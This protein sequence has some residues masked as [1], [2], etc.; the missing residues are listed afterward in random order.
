MKYKIISAVG[1]IL[2][3]LINISSCKKYL[4]IKPDKS[5]VV[6]SSLNDLQ[7]MLDDAMTMN[8]LWP[9]G[10]EVYSDSYYVTDDDWKSLPQIDRLMYI[11]DNEASY[12][13]DWFLTY[14]IILNTNLVLERLEK[15]DDKN[16]DRKKQIK[17][18]ALFF[19]SMAHYVLLQEFSQGYTVSSEN[20][21]EPGIPL[22]LKSDINVESSRSTIREC[23]GVIL[24][25]LQKAL[26]DLPNEV[27][28]KTRPSKTA[29]YALM[30]RINL[31]IGNYRDAGKYAALCINQG[32]TILDYNLV[33]RDAPFERY[34]SEV[35]FHLTGNYSTLLDPTVGK[36]DSNLVNLY[37]P[38]DLRRHLFF[39]QN[40][41]STWAFRGSYDGSA[42]VQMFC[43]LAADEVYLIR[44]E[45]LAREGQD[46]EALAVLNSF[47]KMRYDSSFTPRTAN[48]GNVLQLILNERIKELLF[49]GV[50][51]EDIRRLNTDGGNIVVKRKIQG[52]EYLLAHNDLRYA[53]QIPIDVLA[54]SHIQKNHR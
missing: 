44:A 48:S 16:T 50:R 51:W 23:Y 2:I 39:F 46:N 3:I 25:D 33:N 49:R 32:L 27:L 34:N 36:V 41:D 13:G 14:R 42:S 5:L 28:F 30:A 24:E 40:V 54:Q 38:G 47:L 4:D 31:S 6:P 7:A 12:S 1:L 35:I 10:G 45:C 37:P 8:L 53:Q 19:R 29:G 21:D 43:G 15:I 17:A 9:V 11:F 18:S 22:K 26:P 52:K 20:G